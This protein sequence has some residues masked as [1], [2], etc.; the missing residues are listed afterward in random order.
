MCLPFLGY[1]IEGL[2][3]RNDKYGS[4]IHKMHAFVRSVIGMGKVEE[5]NKIEEIIHEYRDH[6]LTPRNVF[7][8]EKDDGK[9]FRRK[10][11]L[12]LWQKH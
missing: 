1:L 2:N 7:K 5:N 9:L 12:I 4:I 10:I 3:T 6:L 11:N 8:G